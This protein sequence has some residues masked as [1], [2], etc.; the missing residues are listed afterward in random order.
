MKRIHKIAAVNALTI[1]SFLFLFLYSPIPSSADTPSGYLGNALKF[2]VLANS[3]VTNTGSTTVTGTA[4][5]DIGVSTGT[6]IVPGPMTS[7]PLHSNDT[8]AQN[9]QTSLISAFATLSGLPS[10]A[11]TATELGGKTLTAGVYK[12]ATLGVTGTL[13]LNGA[14]DPGS[15]FVFQADSTLITAAAS[16]VVLINQAQACNVY[17]TVGS[18]ATFGTTS[19][20]VGHVLAYASITATTGATIEGQLLARTGAV[21]LDTNTITNNNCATA[22]IDDATATPGAPDTDDATATATATTGPCTSAIRTLVYTSAGPGA[23][24]GKLTWVTQGTG[25]FQFV[26]ASTLYPAPFNYGTRTSSWDGS[27]ANIV[28]GTTY[29]V[30]VRFFS[31]CGV[32]TEASTVVSNAVAVATPTPT[33]TPVITPTPTPTPTVIITPTPT[34]T[35]TVITTPTPTPVVTPTPTPPATEV[36]GKLPKTSSPWY[37]LFLGSAFLGLVGATILIARPRGK[38]TQA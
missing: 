36:A 7:G 22:D 15:V 20:I 34:P 14:G 9:A 1:F 17:W 33:P 25:L 21:T 31:D 38:K 27:L 24:T 19:A 12:Y 23:T 10:T 37:S 29:Q 8:D 16:K 3:T 6:A 18:S 35:P 32:N 28:P 5:S 13:T 26:G 2:A 30:T 11:L 4:G